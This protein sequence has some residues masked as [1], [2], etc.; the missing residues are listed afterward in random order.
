MIGL[1]P[2]KALEPIPDSESIP[3]W[4]QFQQLVESELESESKFS[5]KS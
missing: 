1:D 4:N 3:L 2:I 5:E